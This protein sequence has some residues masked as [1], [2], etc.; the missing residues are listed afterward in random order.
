M[1]PN[2]G[3]IG[4]CLPGNFEEYPPTLEQYHTLRV[5]IKVLVAV[6]KIN[7]AKIFLHKNFAQ[8]FCPGKYFRLV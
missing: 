5:V 3:N 7:P 4:I 6:Y 1:Y 2:K 8:T